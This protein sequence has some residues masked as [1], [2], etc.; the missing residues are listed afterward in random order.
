MNESQEWEEV[1]T[2]I[3][4]IFNFLFLEV[5]YYRLLDLPLFNPRGLFCLES[6]NVSETLNMHVGKT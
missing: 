3:S 2:D 1:I 4:C 6:D 5:G